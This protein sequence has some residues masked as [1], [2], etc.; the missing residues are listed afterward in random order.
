MLTQ[1]TLEQHGGWGRWPS[2]QSG[3]YV[4]YSWPS[5]YVFPLYLWFHIHGFNQPLIV[6]YYSFYSWKKYT[7]NWTHA[8]Q[9]HVV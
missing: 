5:V 1:L 9:I 4:T 7:H 8:M 3:L 2:V 6:Q